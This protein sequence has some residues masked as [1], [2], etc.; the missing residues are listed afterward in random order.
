MTNIHPVVESAATMM[1]Q[2]SANPIDH[3]EANA[4]RINWRQRLRGEIDLA[5]AQVI[6]IICT[7]WAD[8]VPTVVV[9]RRMPN[10]L[11]ASGML[12]TVR[13]N[14]VLRWACAWPSTTWSTSGTATST[15]STVVTIPARPTAGVRTAPRCAATA[16]LTTSPSSPVPTMSRP[17]RPPRARCS[18]PWKLPTAVLAGNDRCA[19]GLLDVSTRAGIAIP[20]ELS[21]M[22][23]DDSHLSDNPRIDL[24]T[25]HQDA[26]ELA[27]HAVDLAV[28]MLEGRRA[29]PTDVVLEPKLVVRS[30]TAHRPNAETTVS[31]ENWFTL[32]GNC[33][34]GELAPR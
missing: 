18:T 17:G 26:P 31:G 11:E 13:T 9:G 28:E 32:V 23:Y 34:V 8:R 4:R 2:Q 19:L 10:I 14:D 16:R 29:E 15:M 12:A 27:H 22:G 33:S 7:N 21:L 3:A 24:T 6:K 1:L 25:I 20:V 5:G 30:T